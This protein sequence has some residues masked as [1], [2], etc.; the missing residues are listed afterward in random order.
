VALLVVPLSAL[1]IGCKIY[2]IMM[3]TD[4]LGVGTLATA[5][6]PDVAFLLLY[7]VFWVV[8]LHCSR[9]RLWLATSVLFS[10]SSFVLL[11]LALVEQAFY[12]STGTHLD[13]YI[14]IHAAENLPMVHAVI[15]SEMG[16]ATW[17]AIAVL[18]IIA[19][20]PWMLHRRAKARPFKSQP[21]TPKDWLQRRNIVY[22]G[23]TTT[24][25]L[26]CSLTSTADLPS[27]LRPTQGNIFV[28]LFQ[29]MQD[30]GVE[31]DLSAVVI[32]RVAPLRLKRRD[33]SPKTNVVLIALESARAQSFNP[34]QNKKTITPFFA[35]LAQ[36]GR[37][38]ERAYTNM[39]HSSKAL[40][41][42][43]CGI[44]PKI[45]NRV[46]EAAPHALPSPCLA[47]LLDEQGYA[48]ALMQPSE[49]HFERASDL[50]SE[51]G[52][53]HFVGK[54]SLSGAGFD[55][56]S[57]FGWEDDV[58][59]QPALDWIDAQ[60]T[61]KKPFFLTLLTLTAHH[62]YS[63]PKGFAEQKYASQTVLNQ[64]LNTLAYTD[65][66][67]K[68]LWK[69]FDERGLAD[70]TLFILVGDHGEGMGEH[71]RFQHDAV[72][73]E[74]GIRVP[75]LVLS[76]R[77]DKAGSPITG[78]RQ[79][80][81]ILP[82]A[83]D[84]LGY[85]T[86]GGALP[87][88]SLL[89]EEGHDHLYV[90]CWYKDYCMARIDKDRKLIHHFDRRDAE[91]FD[92]STD[93]SEK[94]NLRRATDPAWIQES[95]AELLQ[96]QRQTNARYQAQAHNRSHA[97]VSR[98]RPRIATPL[99]AHFGDWM[100]LVGYDA[101]QTTF[102]PGGRL[103]VT[104]YFEALEDAPAGWKLFTH[105]TGPTF[106]N[107]DHVPVDGAY[108]VAQWKKG[109]FIEDRV[110]ITTRPSQEPGEYQL[111]IGLWND[112]LESGNLNQR[113]PISSVLGNGHVDDERRLEVL[114]IHVEA[115]TDRAP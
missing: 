5:L 97:F 63:I 32:P 106:R 4:T 64:Y 29:Q 19:L 110:V 104:L 67:L 93:P 70:D 86:V 38:V 100:R 102:A 82:T 28:Q 3:A 58:L 31:E 78:L 71:G 30:S 9:G 46:V 35:Q 23:A 54:E 48:T 39:T 98:Q 79:Q 115:P 16:V 18:L 22:W 45:Q 53:Q 6:A 74:E 8:L 72:I 17:A 107:V 92:L 75:M 76:P 77:M 21:R 34:Y 73:Y 56:A 62:P 14:L 2:K 24:L 61:N 10:L 65:R 47:Q 12:L 103:V 108:P 101:E 99:M 52:Y 55:E 91:V 80:I 40:V 41:A 96:W 20:A 95:V 68:K 81:D 44:Y 105:L 7:A 109:E 113:A 90:S 11:F 36:R 49:E 69:G 51:F 57:Y 1:V 85:D 15:A 50:I 42:M 114:T 59:I 43:L 112:S 33:D 111:R 87:G 88:R 27:E 66:F 25:L 60:R 37:L 83:L 89:H 94:R 26:A 84:V 13:G